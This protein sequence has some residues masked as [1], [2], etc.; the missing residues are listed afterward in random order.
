MNALSNSNGLKKLYIGSGLKTVDYGAFSKCPDISDIYLKDLKV[1]CEIDFDDAAASSP[2]YTVYD[3]NKNASTPKLVNFHLGWESEGVMTKAD[4]PQGTARIAKCAFLGSSITEAVLP[5]SVESIGENAFRGCKLLSTFTFGA[6]VRTV[7]FDAFAGCDIAVV[8]MNSLKSWCEADLS[9]L[10]GANPVYRGSEI[11]QIHYQGKLLTEIKEEDLAGVKNIPQYRF[12]GCESLTSV[13]I[14]RGAT[15]GEYAFQNCPNLKTVTA[16]GVES[17]GSNAF[18]NCKALESVDLDAK[19]IGAAFAGCTELLSITFGDSVQTVASRAFS[20]SAKV[21]TV[22]FGACEGIRLSGGFLNGGSVTKVRI[23]SLKLWC[24]IQDNGIGNLR[25]ENASLYLIGGEGEDTLVEGRIELPAG[26]GQIPAY[27]FSNMQGITEVVIPNGVESIGNYAFYGVKNITAMNL[28]ESVKSIGSYAF[29][30]ASVKTITGGRIE[31]VGAY[32]F[33]GPN[34]SLPD[35]INGSE[36]EIFPFG[37]SLKEIGEYAFAGSALRAAE[38]LNVE[39]ISKHAFASCES[40]AA[41]SFSEKVRIIDDGAFMRCAALKELVIP[42]TVNTVSFSAFQ[43]CSGLETVE[44]DAENVEGNAFTGA[45]RA[46]RDPW[47]TEGITTKLTVGEHVKHFCA[48]AFTGVGTRLNELHIK[49]LKAWFSIQFDDVG[50][51]GFSNPMNGARLSSIYHTVFVG[52]RELTALTAADLAG[53]TSIPGFAFYEFVSLKSVTLSDTVTSIGEGAFYFCTNLESVT[54]PAT[55]KKIEDFAFNFCSRL[56]TFILLAKD[57]EIGY[58]PFDD[59]GSLRT[60][61]YGGSE[62]EWTEHGYADIIQKNSGPEITVYY[63]SS[64]ENAD[65]RHWH[66]SDNTPAIWG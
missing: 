52:E 51:S 10:G 65:G 42:S 30:D 59:C 18:I 26:I 56:T 21:A 50:L 16:V 53:V 49:S 44:L 64:E 62:A 3:Q 61:Y 9:N 45:F 36:L 32:A 14:P 25:G 38:N 41:V 43:Y 5:D 33:A 46:G 27:A 15:V 66:W 54:V 6:G 19:E 47:E 31:S 20:D 1:W 55:V 23:P 58:S 8:H 24:S 63:F 35:R 2:L 29:Y 22:T 13:T 48:N 17:I 60:L 57:A 28:P 7:G 4:I 40:L 11:A 37:D 34:G 39:T 12:H